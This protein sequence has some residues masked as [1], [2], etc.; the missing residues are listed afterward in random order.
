VKLV[1][2]LGNPGA[3]YAQTKHNV[4]F[5]LIDAFAA[6][7]KIALSERS[8]EAHVGRGHLHTIEGIQDIPFMLAKPQTFMNRSGRSARELVSGLDIGPADV[9]VAHDDLD[10]PCGA[11][12]FRTRGR[13]GGHRGVASIMEALA[14]DR[15]IRVK[16]GIGGDPRVRERDQDVSDY[17]LSPFHAE[18]L[19][20]IL[21]GIERAVSALPLILSGQITEAMNRYHGAST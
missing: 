13:S 10:L 6:Q 3:A 19:A 20:A 12:R 5:W 8:G 15:F 1:I 9:I 4:G 16:M 14:S 18:A 17:V 7:H 21:K 2:G 11:L